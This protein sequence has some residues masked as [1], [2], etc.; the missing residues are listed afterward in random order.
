MCLKSKFCL[1]IKVWRKLANIDFE[2]LRQNSNNNCQEN[3]QIKDWKFFFEQFT[4]ENWNICHIL[5]L[6]ILKISAPKFKLNNFNLLYKKMEF[7][8][9]VNLE[10]NLNKCRSLEYLR[11]K[12][13]ENS[14]ITFFI[15]SPNPQEY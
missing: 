9:A 5:L 1:K 13:N 6:K 2:F 7:W 3:S 11:T 12:M 15:Q 8:I 10:I 14:S 4:L